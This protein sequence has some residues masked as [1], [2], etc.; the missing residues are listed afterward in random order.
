MRRRL[1]SL[2]F[3][4]LVIA[5]A[6]VFPASVFAQQSKLTTEYI[7][8]IRRN[9]ISAQVTLQRVQ[10]SDV[11]VRINRGQAYDELMTKL[12]EPFNSR[13]ALNKLSQASSLTE[14]TTAIQNALSTFKQR[15]VDY[16]DTLSKTLGIKCQDTPVTFYDSL[17]RTRELRSALGGDLRAIKAA[18]ETYKQEIANIQKTI[19]AQQ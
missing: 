11:V 2:V 1:N 12:I 9:C 14:K 8:K 3:V 19:G 15:Y 17:T 6:A 13:A 18:I 10:Y 5:S 4:A 7:D 16:E